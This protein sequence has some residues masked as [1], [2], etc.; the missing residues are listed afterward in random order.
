MSNR[1]WCKAVER[2]QRQQEDFVHLVRNFDLLLLG[3]LLCLPRMSRVRVAIAVILIGVSPL[4]GSASLDTQLVE[5]GPR[6]F[7]DVFQFN[8]ILENFVLQCLSLRIEQEKFGPL[9]KYVHQSNRSINV[10]I[11][12]ALEDTT[13]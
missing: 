12:N 7:V 11:V 2:H 1:F 6:P 5:N 4:Q 8:Q 9:C 3:I 10:G 13:W